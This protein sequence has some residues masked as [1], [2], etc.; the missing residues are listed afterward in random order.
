MVHAGS[1]LH[2]NAPGITKK[3]LNNGAENIILHWVAQHGRDDFGASETFVA[4]ETRSD[5]R[6][7]KLH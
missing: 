5:P 4:A 1:V 6:R 7:S 3:S 2:E